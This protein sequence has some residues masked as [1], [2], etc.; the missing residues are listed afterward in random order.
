MVET[1]VAAQF[2]SDATGRYLSY[3]FRDGSAISGTA[4]ADYD[5]WSRW[6]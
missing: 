5:R 4:L 1:V 2:T 3:W 6:R